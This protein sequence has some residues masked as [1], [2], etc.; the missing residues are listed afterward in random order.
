MKILHITPTL[1]PNVGGIETVVRELMRN[2][3][4]R[5]FVADAMQIAPGNRR[6]KEHLD[7]S[8]V[9]RMPLFPNRLIGLLPPARSI[10]SQYDVLHVHDPQAMAI[11]FNS[12]LQGRGK[13]IVLSTHGGYHHT[14]KYHLVKQAHWKLLAPFILNR[15][16]EVLASSRADWELFRTKAPRARLVPNG[17]NIERF[18][19]VDPSRSADPTRWIYWGRLSKNK[20]LDVLI[21]LVAQCREAGFVIDLLIAGPDFD[22]L[23]PSLLARLDL[24][25]LGSQI[26]F[27]G[28]IS[29]QQLL[30][31]I[32][33]RA[34]FVSAS[35]YEGFGLSVIEAMAAG[36]IILCRDMQPLNGF[37]ASKSNGFYLRFDGG[38]ADLAQLTTLL[39]SP[40]HELSRMRNL[41]REAAKAHSWS[42]VI[43]SYIDIYQG[44]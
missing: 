30:T 42:A 37:V 43:Q 33:S 18:L 40:K 32:S 23:L 21:D 44:R 16:D 41:A 6:A 27:A 29:D 39:G 8:I 22:H 7:E 12:L 1:Y 25:A 5:G 15:Y 14:S 34:V 2:L 13:R 4:C 9:W 31:E 35:E 24:L 36:L 17:V 11:S 19:S 20:R 26:R 38:A 3:R 28:P 10:L